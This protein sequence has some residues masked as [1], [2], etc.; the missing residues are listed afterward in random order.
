MAR[1]SVSGVETGADLRYVREYSD[2]VPS[3]ATCC[4]VA[5]SSV[6]E[7]ERPA[8]L[9]AV[10]AAVCSFPCFQDVKLVVS[11]WRWHLELWRYLE[12]SCF[13]WLVRSQDSN[14]E[15]VQP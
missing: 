7:V 1:L 10:L 15:P 4:S 13:S 2:S 12:K 14:L 8:G 11:P 5:L 3:V 6:S 9:W